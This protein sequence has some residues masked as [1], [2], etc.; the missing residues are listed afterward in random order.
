MKSVNLLSKGHR[1]SPMF[2]YYASRTRKEI[3][4][5][6]AVVSRSKTDDRWYV[7]S[8]IKIIY[9]N[10]PIPVPCFDHV[11]GSTEV[12]VP[13]QH[14]K[15]SHS[16]RNIDLEKKTQNKTVCDIRSPIHVPVSFWRWKCSD[17]QSSR[18]CIRRA[19]IACR[20][21]IDVQRAQSNA[22]SCLMACAK[23]TH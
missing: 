7:F 10:A 20:L 18:E 19:Q 5:T 9:K 12:S 2:L 1:S 14:N 8:P 4:W 21:N 3:I 23:T 22:M 13:K 11:T 6:C 17:K 15:S 16:L